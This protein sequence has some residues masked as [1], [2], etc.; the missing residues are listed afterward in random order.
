MAVASSPR[1][2]F[3]CRLQA[4]RT[5]LYLLRHTRRPFLGPS[6]SEIA[7][8]SG[9]EL[10]LEL[11]EKASEGWKANCEVEQRCFKRHEPLPPMF[12]C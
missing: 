9:R 7:K 11:V 6:P 2:S 5:A 3:E 8:G 4:C 1:A 10:E 12:L